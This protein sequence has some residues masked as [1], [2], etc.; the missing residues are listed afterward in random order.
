M[1][2]RETGKRNEVTENIMLASDETRGSS[3]LEHS[4]TVRQAVHHYRS[5]IFWCLA[6]S[7]TVVMEGYDTILLGNLWA[8][9]TFQLKY[10]EYVGVSSQ[11]RSGYQLTP[12]WQAGLGNAAG[13]GAFFGAL[14]NGILVNRFG[15]RN[16]IVASL[17]HSMGIFATS[18]PAY[19]SEMLPMVLR[20][21]FTSWTNMCFII[22]QFIAS[23][24]LRVCLSRD[25]EWGF[26]IPFALQTNWLQVVLACL[27]YPNSYVRTGIAMA[28]GAPGKLEE[29]ERSINRLQASDCPISHKQALIAIVETNKA[30]KDLAVG[31]SYKHCFKGVELRRTEIAC[32]CFMG[33]VLCGLP[34]AYNAT[35]FYEQIGLPANITYSLNI[36]GYGLALFSAFCSWFFLLP[37]VGRRKIYLGGAF[38]MSLLLYLIAILTSWKQRHGV[39]EA[40]AYLTIVWKA[41][42]QLSAGQLGWAIPA[43]VGS[44]RLR[45]KTI[46]LARNSYYLVH[47][48]GTSVQPYFLNPRALDLGARAAFVWAT[49]ALLFF[50]WAFFRLPETKNLTYEELNRLF[51]QRVPSR[52]F[53][54]TE[55]SIVKHRESERLA[56]V[57][58]GASQNSVV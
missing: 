29:A 54:K 10:G 18:A 49:T 55:A 35:Y 12:A 34:I 46:V 23:G 38:T 50:A 48:V 1:E 40:Q 27:A 13:V 28:S 26:R 30:E 37:R 32:M 14:L 7:M 15:Q 9:P 57:A 41:A 2:R 11:T 44:T 22:G 3:T 24:V 47:T 4:I 19:A 43:E 5:A 58:T 56:S 17:W 6:V 36:G 45:Q 52:E 33:Q 51:A 42:F 31:T 20:V 25:D 53:A 21:Y 8:Y 16:T 39:A